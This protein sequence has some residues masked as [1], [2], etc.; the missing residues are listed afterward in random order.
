[1]IA[2]MKIVD[3]KGRPAEVMGDLASFF[4]KAT[5]GP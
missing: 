4:R 1:M 2:T 3:R 5:I